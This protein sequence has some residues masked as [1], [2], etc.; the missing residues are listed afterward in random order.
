[1]R[2]S[3][4]WA[5]ILNLPIAAPRAPSGPPLRPGAQNRPAIDR[6][7]TISPNA[8]FA[9]LH[10]ICRPPRSVRISVDRL[11]QLLEYWRSRFDHPAADMLVEV[12]ISIIHERDLAVQDVMTKI[13]LL[14][15]YPGLYA[16]LSIL[17]FSCD[18]PDKRL[19]PVDAAIRRRWGSPPDA[20]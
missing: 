5:S 7:I 1:M 15:D 10:E 20:H 18:D 4:L 19:E 13:G 2:P 14:A 17:Y 6:G 8:A 16:A 12:A 3:S 11:I 9:V